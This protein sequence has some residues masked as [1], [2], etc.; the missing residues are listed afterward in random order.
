MSLCAIC[1]GQIDDGYP[2]DSYNL[3]YDGCEEPDDKYRN[4]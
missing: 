3:N 4:R 1:Y 2:Y